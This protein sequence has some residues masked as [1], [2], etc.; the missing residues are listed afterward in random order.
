L[1]LRL[2]ESTTLTAIDESVGDVSVNADA[3][4]ASSVADRV[5][6]LER[7]LED[8][9]RV[10][11]EW[12]S[13]SLVAKGMPRGGMAEAEEWLFLATALRAVRQLAV[14]LAEAAAG[15]EP[16][17]A[18]SRRLPG[19]VRAVRAFP[20]SRL[21]RLVYR[22]LQGEVRLQ[23]GHDGDR[24]RPAPG[25]GAKG[26]VAAVL[27]AGNASMLPAVDVL[28]QLF[29]ERRVVVLKPSPVN[30]YLGPLLE[31]GFRALVDAGFV[32]L[33]YGG[34]DEGSLLCRHE[35]V[36]AVHLT[37]SYATYRAIVSGLGERSPKHITSELGNVSPIIVVP[38]PWS[39]RD[40]ERQAERIATWLVANAGFGC[41]TPRVLVQ[42]REWPLRGALLDA[43]RRVLSRVETRPAYYPGAAS[44]FALFT[45]AHPEARLLGKGG[46]GRLPWAVIADVDAEAVDDP[47]FRQEAFCG[48]IAETA[49][50]APSQ[51]AFLER[52]VE[53]ANGVLWGT[54]SATLLVHPAS[55]RDPA[56]AGAVEA[57]IDGLRY[58]TVTVNSAAF[59]AY[60]TQVL[61]W[62]A[63]PP[64]EPSEIESGCGKTANGLFLRGAQKSVLRGRF[65]DRPDPFRVTASRPDL[66]ARRLAAYA[67]TGSTRSLP[68][69]AAAAVRGSVVAPG[70]GAQ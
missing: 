6:L 63:F 38:G 49:L 39:G 4:A 32:R 16:L 43:L 51:E 35:G 27:G 44:R 28:H 66:A 10:A 65:T 48:L 26:G 18:H 7:V 34:A 47:C 9:P 41:L 68:R 69:L 55:L 62:G 50:P 1:S 53:F 23:P 5:L 64:E 58:G 40:V 31:H 11:E 20:R 57:A 56:L 2:P 45:A 33:V 8:L 25:E 60:H 67:A 14:S 21:D 70:G 61:P 42:H 52:A 3:W 29:L 12:I 30:A 17:G 24:L 13:T 15:E 19:G 36:D 46:G 22:G 54:L 59:A 37:G